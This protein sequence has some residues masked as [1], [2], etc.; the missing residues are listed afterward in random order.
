MR[1]APV[2]AA[3]WIV[4]SAC[5][6]AGTDNRAPAAASSASEVIAATASSTNATFVSGARI[7]AQHQGGDGEWQTPAG[8]YASSRYSPLNQITPENAHGLHAA[9]TFSTGV[10]RGHE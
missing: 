2:A 9:W 4:V 10:L 8:D 7:A 6:P 5:S 1:N 3:L